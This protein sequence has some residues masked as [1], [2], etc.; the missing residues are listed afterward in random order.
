MIESYH[1]R[2]GIVVL[3]VLTFKNIWSEDSLHLNLLLR[4]D[5]FDGVRLK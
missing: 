5:R 3:I 2:S 1:Y 4:C